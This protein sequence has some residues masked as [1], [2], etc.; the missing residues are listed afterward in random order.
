LIAT[1]FMFFVIGTLGQIKRLLIQIANNTRKPMPA[2][3]K[4]IP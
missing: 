2:P 1:L 4:K 3:I